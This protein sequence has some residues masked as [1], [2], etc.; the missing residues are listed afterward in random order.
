MLIQAI[1]INQVIA[2]VMSIAG[3]LADWVGLVL[4]SDVEHKEVRFRVSD[5]QRTAALFAVFLGLFAWLRGTF[6]IQGDAR[7]QALNT[8]AAQQARHV[9][10]P[11]SVQSLYSFVLNE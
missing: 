3:Y 1:G 5:Q 7:S 11:V 6:T 2:L 8:Q 9:Y 10:A 4:L